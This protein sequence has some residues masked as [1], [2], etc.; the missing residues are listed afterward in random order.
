MARE[1]CCSGNNEPHTSTKAHLHLKFQ[2]QT[3]L[4]HEWETLLVPFKKLKLKKNW[5]EVGTIASYR[6]TGWVWETT[7]WSSRLQGNY[8]SFLW[9]PWNIPRSKKKNPKKKPAT[10]RTWK[11]QLG[12]WPTVPKN[13]PGHWGIPSASWES[14]RTEVSMKIWHS[15]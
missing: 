6:W 5:K 7:G 3:K 15:D 10:G 9:N 2:T 13:L 12:S 11:H 8:Q 1:W 14:I 4:S